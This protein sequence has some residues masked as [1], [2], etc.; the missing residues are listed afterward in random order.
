MNLLE[1]FINDGICCKCCSSKESIE[2]I[3][4]VKSMGI[5]IDA[6]YGIS[7]FNYYRIN[8]NCLSPIIFPMENPIDFKEI[9]N[10]RYD[11]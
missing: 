4:I 5:K 7:E 2:L 11:V 10:E 3:K 9:F 1:K 8:N 6:F